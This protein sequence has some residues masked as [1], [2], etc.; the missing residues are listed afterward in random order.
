V[1]GWACTI[2][3][4][5]HMQPVS[6]LS[7]LRIHLA[8]EAITN[9]T[10]ATYLGGDATRVYLLR[11]H[12]VPTTTGLASVIAART[13]LT[14]SQVVFIVLGFAFF[15]G[16]LGWGH[17]GWWFLGPVLLAG[18]GFSVWL[19]RWQRR[20]LIERVVRTMRY[21]FPRWQPLH[22]WEAH[23]SQIDTHL[24]RL[25][26]GNPQAFFASMASYFLGWLLGAAEV[27]FFF[28]FIGAN[29]SPLD[30]LIL[31]AMVQP[32]TAAALIIP[33]ALGVK[34]AGAVALCQLLGLD[35]S[36]GLTVMVLKRARQA[37]YYLVGLLVLARAGYTA[38]SPDLHSR[39]AVA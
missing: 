7:L 17:Q 31:E 3:Y 14:V 36:A 22:R 27:F 28:L 2:P 9:L 24:V 34:E 23:A 8:S 15:L 6:L 26:D 35:E 13:A 12:G 1:K 30:A 4:T 21:R 16:H 11:S 20:G 18:Y 33:G 29:A 5:T 39:D 37:L 25:Y 19:I 32:F 10:P 38:L